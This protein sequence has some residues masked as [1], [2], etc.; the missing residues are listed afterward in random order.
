MSMDEYYQMYLEETDYRVMGEIDLERRVES[1]SEIF[2]LSPFAKCWDTRKKLFLK[3]CV[4][5]TC[6]V[7]GPGDPV[8]TFY[9]FDPKRWTLRL[10]KNK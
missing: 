9:H 3:K 6:A 10:L 1:I 8:H 5:V 4:K 7:Y 2:C